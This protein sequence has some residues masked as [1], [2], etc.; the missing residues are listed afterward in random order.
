MDVLLTRYNSPQ[1]LRNMPRSTRTPIA[2]VFLAALSGAVMAAALAQQKAAL[3]DGVDS[4]LVEYASPLGR[5]FRSIPDTGGLVATAEKELQ[6]NR[7]HPG[8]WLKLAQAQAAVWQDREAVITLTHAIEIAPDNQA[9]YT[10]RGHR[11]LA[12]REF[13][14]AVA[15]LKRAVSLDDKSVEAYYHLGLAYYFQGE[16]KEAAATFSKAVDFAP[17]TDNRINSTNWLYA[18]LRRA[19][20][21]EAASKALA[22]ITPDMQA[23]EPHTAFYL[24][25]VRFFQGNKTESVVVPPPPAPGAPDIEPELRYDT[26]AYGVGNW[27]LY[28]GEPGK[29]RDYF[30]RIMKGRVWITWGFVGA[31]MELLRMRTSGSKSPAQR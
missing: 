11:E 25:L 3:P 26:I 5:E 4:T 2:A 28:N 6:N 1:P 19:N 9:L 14:R 16:F 7:K 24:D 13:A 12:L 27:H 22:A 10:E 20:E 23:T 15:D 18:S 17:N 30:E 31:E 21:P 8:M 29:A